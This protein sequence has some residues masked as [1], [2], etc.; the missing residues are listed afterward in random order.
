MAIDNVVAFHLI[1]AKGKALNLSASSTGEELALF[2]A[3]CG[4][5]HGIGVVTS[6]TLKVFP[7]ARLKMADN[8]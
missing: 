2:N 7:L 1:T 4:G 8:Q 5:G 6:V 3:L